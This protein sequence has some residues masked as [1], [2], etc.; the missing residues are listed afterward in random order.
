M[1]ALI[2]YY[3]GEGLCLGRFFEYGRSYSVYI[4]CNI[5]IWSRFVDII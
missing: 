1:T 3:Q 5:Y 2:Q 4:R